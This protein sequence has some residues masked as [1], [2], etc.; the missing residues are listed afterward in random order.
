MPDGSDGGT[1]RSDE[2]SYTVTGLDNGVEQH[3]RREQR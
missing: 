1:D 3:L 2:W